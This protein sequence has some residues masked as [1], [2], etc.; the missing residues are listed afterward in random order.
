MFSIIDRLKRSTVRGLRSQLDQLREANI[1]L[2][3]S[4]AKFAG[5]VSLS[6]DAFIILDR[7]QNITFF[8][9]GAEHIFGYSMTEALGQPMAIL[10]PESQRSTYRQQIQ[11]FTS[12]LESTRVIE[13]NST[14]LYGVRK[15]GDIFP[16][17]AGIS[18]IEVGGKLLLTLV[19]RDISVRTQIQNQQSFLAKAG[20]LWAT[21]LEDYEATLTNIANLAVENIADI[22]IIDIVDERNEIRRIK[23]SSNSPANDELC[24]KLKDVSLDRDRPHIFYD[25]LK[26]K[27]S[28]LIPKVTRKTIEGYAQNEKHLEILKKANIKSL[29]VVPLIA[30]GKLIGGIAFISSNPNRFYNNED[31]RFSE[32]LALRAALSIENARL[33]R[34]SQMAIKTREDV[35]AIVSH[36]LKNPIATMGLAADLL[37]KAASCDSNTITDIAKTIRTSV[38]QTNQLI[39]DLLDFAKIQSGSLSVDIY[40]EK[41]SDF[42]SPTID[43]LKVL[44]NSRHQK[45]LTDIPDNLKEVACDRHRI[46]QVLSNLLGNAIKF[47]PDGGTILVTAR[48]EEHGVSV[49]V[50]DNGP[51]IAKDDLPKIFDRFWQAKKTQHLGTGLGLSIAKGIILAHG[52]QIWAESDLGKGS[53]FTFSLPFATDKTPKHILKDHSLYSSR[54]DENSLKGIRVLVVDDSP[55]MVFLIKHVLQR[56]GCMVSEANSV[57]EAMKTLQSETPDI[58]LTDIEMPLES[59]YELLEKIKNLPETSLNFHIPVVA[60]T[61][62]SRAQELE[63]IKETGFE[64]TLSKPVNQES[65]LRA[66]KTLTRQSSLVRLH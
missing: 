4:E 25:A 37:S 49:S 39:G 50:I 38:N 61:A 15:N 66:V 62:H 52:G 29:I 46:A 21:S 33:Y 35:L 24:Q 54:R 10:V 45:L 36:D 20:T 28:T 26:F 42:M 3:L 53:C 60:L 17:E 7:N 56:A 41:L 27:H 57:A 64:L 12:G 2:Q 19:I 51:G 9:L 63:K 8:N 14:T 59:G 47:T 34:N 65:L 11:Q 23:V 30:S 13:S 1:A 43:S 40:S 6:T 16:V 22:C 32:E 31:L 48:Q 55:E 5:I 44:A 18:R 58:I